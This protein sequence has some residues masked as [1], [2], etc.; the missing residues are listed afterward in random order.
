[1]NQYGCGLGSR[2][3]QKRNLRLQKLLILMYI[4][5]LEAVFR[6]CFYVDIFELG[7][8]KRNLKIEL[9]HPETMKTDFYIFVCIF[10]SLPWTVLMKVHFY[11]NSSRGI[12]LENVFFIKLMLGTQL[13]H[14]CEQFFKVKLDF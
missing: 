1:M 14:Y 4:I 5:Y 10:I 12:D 13:V 6:V 7:W 11:G 3:P 9:A 2:N 8:V